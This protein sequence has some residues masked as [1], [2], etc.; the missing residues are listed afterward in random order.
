M[1]VPN[2]HLQFLTLKRFQNVVITPSKI[3]QERV[4]QNKN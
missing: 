1:L 2:C 4:L 3:L